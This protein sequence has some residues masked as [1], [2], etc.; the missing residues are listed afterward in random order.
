ML[1]S[2]GWRESTHQLTWETFGDALA[3]VVTPNMLPATTLLLLASLHTTSSIQCF[4]SLHSSPAH[5]VTC[6]PGDV[7]YLEGLLI[8]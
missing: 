5:L 2:D 7:C 6:R 3:V 8:P 4:S 1:L